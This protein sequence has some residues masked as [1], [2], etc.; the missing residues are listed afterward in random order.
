MYTHAP[1]R[2]FASFEL[3]RSLSMY[4]LK[5]IELHIDR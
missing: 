1:H 3:S 5:H 4:I 2:M